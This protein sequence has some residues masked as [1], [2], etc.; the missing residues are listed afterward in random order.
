MTQLNTVLGELSMDS[1]V[2]KVILSCHNRDVNEMNQ[3]ITERFSGEVNM[4]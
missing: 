1:P 2:G 4:Q 3:K